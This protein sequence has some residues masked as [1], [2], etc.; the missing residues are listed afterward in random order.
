MELLVVLLGLFLWAGA[1]PVP[2]KMDSIWNKENICQDWDFSTA[3]GVEKLW[4]ETAAG[5]SLDFFLEISLKAHPITTTEDAG[6]AFSQNKANEDWTTKLEHK[7]RSNGRPG[8][9]GCSTIGGQCSPFSDWDCERYYDETNKT[10][11]GRNSYW[12]FQ[13]VIG[14]HSKIDKIN[15]EI[16]RQTLVENLKI[17]Q[18]LS[19]FDAPDTK[20]SS[21]F[22]WI[23]A[24]ASMGGGLMS[25]PGAA[26]IPGPAGFVTARLAIIGSISSQMADAESKENTEAS[27]VAVALGN[28]FESLTKGL[29]DI[30]RVATGGGIDDNEY[31]A[32]PSL[33][34][35]KDNFLSKVPAF[36]NGGWPLLA[37]NS[38]EFAS[39]VDIISDNLKMKV[40]TEAMKASKLRMVADRHRDAET[41]EGCGTDIGRQW[42]ELRNGEEYCFYLMRESAG[43]FWYEAEPRIYEAMERH[44][45]G[46]RVPFYAAIIDCAL[47]GNGDGV[48]IGGGIGKIPRYYFDLPAVFYDESGNC[49]DPTNDGCSTVKT[50]PLS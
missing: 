17:S 23:A 40:A 1:T 19:E 25:L 34:N 39:W 35:E 28:A 9:G 30:L 27:N 29:E 24:A 46:N 45:I 48:E 49:V 22:K 5:F 47:N 26:M 33:G 50:S 32:L 37:E 11:F 44:G 14:L 12:V 13:A 10:G 4:Q 7:I 38:R 20:A 18:T 3:E 2:E 36:L 31:N 6:V 42:M 43:T 8:V 21:V 15:E 41:R 16:T